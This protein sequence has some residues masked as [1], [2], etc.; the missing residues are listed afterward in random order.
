MTTNLDMKP[1]NPI[2]QPSAEGAAAPETSLRKGKRGTALFS[3]CV[4]EV[5]LEMGILPLA[6]VPTCAQI[7]D[8]NAIGIFIYVLGMAAWLA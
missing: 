4:V 8:E 3:W 7:A 1:P 2:Q 5:V 6:I